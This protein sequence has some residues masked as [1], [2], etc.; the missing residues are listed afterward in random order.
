MSALSLTPH[1][2]LQAHKHYSSHLPEVHD[3]KDGEEADV[4][5]DGDELGEDDH[6]PLSGAAALSGGTLTPREYRVGVPRA[7]T[8]PV[9]RTRLVL[10]GIAKVRTYPK[11]E[12]LERE[13]VWRGLEEGM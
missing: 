8:V 4:H 3:L 5:K 11:G 6:R 12:G 1:P 7:L 10:T 2:T 9:E 13:E